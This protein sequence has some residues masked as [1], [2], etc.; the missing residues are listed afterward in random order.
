V[1][2]Q[3]RLCTGMSINRIR[4]QRQDLPAKGAIITRSSRRCLFP[5]R[6]RL[7]HGCETAFYSEQVSSCWGP[8]CRVFSE[9]RDRRLMAWPC[10]LGHW[11]EAGRIQFSG[12]FLHQPAEAGLTLAN[13][14][15]KICCNQGE[16]RFS[17]FSSE[18][19][20]RRYRRYGSTKQPPVP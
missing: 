13:E 10:A 19:R 7:E 17:P 9:C 3:E 5:A 15:L 2:R 16:Y 8:M 18:Q 20:P 4:P 6:S 11:L 12:C 1:S 14:L